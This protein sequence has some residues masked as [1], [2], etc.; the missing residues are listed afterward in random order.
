MN[1]R[2]DLQTQ[3]AKIVNYH[4]LRTVRTQPRLIHAVPHTALTLT[5]L[6]LHRLQFPSATDVFRLIS[7]F[8]RLTQANIH[9]CVMPRGPRAAPL[10]SSTCLKK[11]GYTIARGDP[12]PSADA[13]LLAQWWQWPHPHDDS[14]VGPYPGLHQADTRGMFT[15]LKFLQPSRRDE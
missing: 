7:L 6:R 9:K 12:H 2:L 14:D 11:L 4:H 10:P 13:V 8:P 1:S 15:M 3:A 5:E